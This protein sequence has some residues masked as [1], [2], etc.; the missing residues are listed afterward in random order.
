MNTKLLLTASALALIIGAP[1]SATAA[2]E[3]TSAK[4]EAEQE[5][6]IGQDIEKGLNEAGERISDAAN[7]VAEATKDTYSSIKAKIVDETQEPQVSIIDIDER[8]TAAGMIGTPV[9]NA[10]EERIAKV[11]DII[12][13]RDGKAIMVILADGDFT[14]LGKHVAFEY[15]VITSRN[16]DGDLI[17]PLSEED[18]DNAMAFSY[19]RSDYS[20]TVQVIPSNGFSVAEL[21]ESNLTDPKGET[22]ANVDNISFSGG[23]ADQLILKFNDVL[24]FG[25]ETVAMGYGDLNIARTDG[26]V[27]FQL[28]EAQTTEFKTYKDVITQ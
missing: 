13:D 14:G 18:I 26:K 2:E 1:V 12:L 20:D 23:A 21:M 25:G 28:T 8:M 22:L 15:D 11:S 5:T 19:D 3:N 6:S 27:N 24:G 9:Y 16:A 10:A 4:V 17:A 7:N